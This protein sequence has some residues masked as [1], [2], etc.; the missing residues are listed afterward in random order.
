MT[1]TSPARPT[2]SPRSV[3]RRL[4]AW[5]EDLDWERPYVDRAA[6]LVDRGGLAPRLDHVPP[7]LLR[8]TR[9]VAV[10]VVVPCYNYGRFLPQ[11]VTSALDQGDA[12]LA[13]EVVVV[14]DASTD[15]S[16]AVAERLAAAD[17]R[18]RL[19]RNPE[20]LGHV[21]TFNRGLEETSGDHVVRLDADDLLTPGSL[22]RAAA[23]L[24]AH[25]EVGLVYGHPR[26]FVTADPPRPR[27]GRV[28]WSVWDGHAWVR[29]RCRLGVNCLTTPEAVVR[30]SVLREVGGLNT[31]LRYAQDMEMWLRVAAVSDVAR[32]NDVDQALHR[33][34]DASMSVNEG[35]GALT[36]LRERR[37]VFAELLRVMGGVFERP[38]ELDRQWRRTL[39]GEALAR[40]AHE[41]DR[42]RFDPYF[43][44]DLRSFALSTW[45]GR[46]VR[47][48]W[49]A[50][51]RRVL[52]PPVPVAADLRVAHRRLRDELS[53]LRW[54]RTGV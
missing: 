12:T 53:Y 21:R 25:P 30:A 23:L 43:H 38:Q 15:D 52:R 54:C 27:H 11:A 28:T 10:S 26:H 50:L 5:V 3:P 1:V 36:D 31:A 9:P 22:A 33:D 51:D 2:V 42:G 14:D 16:A 34:H 7:A 20:N 35:A 39:A 44:A 8:P 18:V 32:V 45:G 47:D 4:H 17:P 46:E 40:A 48:A 49:R 37:Q 19:V 41:W 29:E 24:Q 13:V 6:R